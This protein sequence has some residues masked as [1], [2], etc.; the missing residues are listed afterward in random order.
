LQ[1][2]ETQEESYKEMQ[3]LADSMMH[4]ADQ[5]DKLKDVPNSKEMYRTISKYPEIMEE[6]VDFIHHWLKSWLGAYLS[7][8]DRISTEP[9]VQPSTFSLSLRRTGL[10]SYGRRWMDSGTS[11][12]QILQ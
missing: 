8:W 12:T 10:L 4:L 3:G 1:H 2:L 7:T 5:L 6:V 11:L 9:L